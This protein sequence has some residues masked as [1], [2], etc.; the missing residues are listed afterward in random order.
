MVNVVVVRVV[1]VVGSFGSVSTV[2]AAAVV[3]PVVVDVVVRARC[4][5][6]ALNLHSRRLPIV[7]YTSSHRYKGIVCVCAAA[8]VVLYSLRSTFAVVAVF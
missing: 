6:P 8:A 4:R 5:P 2:A 7:F 3:Y 1:A